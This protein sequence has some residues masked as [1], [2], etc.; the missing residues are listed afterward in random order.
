MLR[1]AV[2]CATLVPVCLGAPLRGAAELAKGQDAAARADLS[3]PVSLAI[4]PAA[5][6]IRGVAKPTLI[7][8]KAFPDAGGMRGESHE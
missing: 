6:T 1:M 7:A 4:T 2:L 3:P 8:I 5:I